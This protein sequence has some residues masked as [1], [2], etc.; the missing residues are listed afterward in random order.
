VR[1]G[2]PMFAEFMDAWAIAQAE[3]EVYIAALPQWVQ[4]WMNW[5]MLVLGLGA[6]V[7][8][9]FKVEARWLLLAMVLTIPA[10]SEEHT[11]EL[12]SRQYIV[13]RLLLEKTKSFT[14][15]I[16]KTV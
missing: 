16:N 10:R 2:D 12:Q 13:C 11:S 15:N 3:Q 9:V 6:L 8:A 14:E 7:F 5:M 1:E 4:L